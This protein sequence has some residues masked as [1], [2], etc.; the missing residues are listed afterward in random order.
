M[1]TATSSAD[2]SQTAQA[3][4]Q[5]W[6]G[7]ML[8][9]LIAC[10][11]KQTN[12]TGQ[13]TL[14]GSG[15][16]A[17]T[18]VAQPTG[19]GVANAVGY[20]VFTFSDTLAGGSLS[21]AAI[22]TGGS[23][24]TNGTYTGLTVT[25][26]ISGATNAVGTVVV[27]GGAATTL[28]ITT[29]GSGYIV[30]EK[31][32]VSN[33][34]VPTAANWTATALGSGNPVIFRLDFGAGAATTDPQMWITVGAGTN[35]AGTISG[36]AGTSKMTQVAVGAGSAPTSTTT[37]YS[38]YFCVNMTYGVAWAAFKFSGSGTA[39]TAFMGFCLFRT[40][41]S[42]GAANGN[43]I[44]LITN[45]STTTGNLTTPPVVQ[46]MTWSSGAGSTVYPTL[47]ANNSTAYSSGAAQYTSGAT[48]T[49]FGLTS[50][51]ENSTAFVFPIYTISPAIAFSNVVGQVLVGDVS[52]GT[53]FSA[54]LIGATALTYLQ[55]GAPCGVA[56]APGAYTQTAGNV[57]AFAWL[58]Q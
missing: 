26:A 48:N 18:N 49:I 42:T 56:Y 28:T 40:S 5:A 32:T 7:E 14:T 47:Q 35:G 45:S 8:G 29:A 24:G 6:T 23:G 55:V 3:G 39:Y 1:T 54:T 30:G 43:A 13:L 37:P 9:Q 17:T 34:S 41:G 25:G 15:A 16:S 22:N 52:L 11:L 58:Y 57:V 10:G 53:S 19:T 31:L 20:M 2:L 27:S 50:S 44:G 4:T 21:T 33:V 36:T 51:L 12:D 38:S 46:Y